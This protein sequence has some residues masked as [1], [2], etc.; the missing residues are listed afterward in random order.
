MKKGHADVP[1]VLAADFSGDGI[2]DL[3][4]QLNRDELKITLGDASES[5]F[6]GQSFKINASLPRNG[7]RVQPLD[8]DADGL[9]DLVIQYGDADGPELSGKLSVLLAVHDA[10][11]SGQ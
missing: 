8:V 11:A 2:K 9:S 10:G 1:A 6:A 5:L 3:L 7:D 4:L